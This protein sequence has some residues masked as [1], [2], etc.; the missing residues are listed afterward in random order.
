QKFKDSQQLQKKL[1]FILNV[2]FAS[3]YIFINL[4]QN[5]LQYKFTII[6]GSLAG[7]FIIYLVPYKLQ[8]RK[9]EFVKKLIFKRKNINVSGLFNSMEECQEVDKSLCQSQLNI[10]KYNQKKQIE[11][12]KKPFI[13]EANVYDKIILLFGFFISMYGIFSFIYFIIN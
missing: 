2:I 12:I 5:D 3:F 4:A 10:E 8:F 7:F 9:Q 1:K 6:T 13:K 11:I